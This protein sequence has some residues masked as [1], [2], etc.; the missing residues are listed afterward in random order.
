MDAF[1]SAFV[2]F[3]V[4]LVARIPAGVVVLWW[5]LIRARKTARLE[6]TA[7][8]EMKRHLRQ[9]GICDSPDHSK[10]SNMAKFLEWM[11]ERT[12]ELSGSDAPCRNPRA[13]RAGSR[14]LM[15]VWS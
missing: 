6:K 11:A 7:R 3:A 14:G 4:V 13:A 5:W 8:Q 15:L 2:I 9:I 12:H 10:M 1:T